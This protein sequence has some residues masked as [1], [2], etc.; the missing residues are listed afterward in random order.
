MKVEPLIMSRLAPDAFMVTGGT[1]D[2]DCTN[3]RDSDQFFQNFALLYVFLIH[4]RSLSN[5]LIQ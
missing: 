5:L 3:L 2:L 1:L 4:Q